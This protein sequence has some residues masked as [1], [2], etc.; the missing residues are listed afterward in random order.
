MKRVFCWML[1][2]FTIII[3]TPQAQ[4]F[5]GINPEHL[6]S[7]KFDFSTPVINSITLP[8]N[9]RLEYAEQGNPNGIPVI[10]LHG[11]SD[12]WH[13]F[14]MIM[15]YLPASLH[16]YSISQRGHGNS[17]KPLH[18]YKPEDFA[19]DIAD[20]MKVMDI[21]NPLLIG[22]SMGSTIVQCFASRYTFPTRGIILI[23]AFAD[24]ERP[25]IIEFK[26]IIDQLTDPVDSMFAAEFQKSTAYR[27]IPHSMMKL[28]IEE[29]G[30]LPAYVWKGVAAGWST[31][32]YTSQL[33]NYKKPALLIWGDKDNFISIKDQE[34]LQQPL[35]KSTLNVYRGTGHPTHWE[36]PE[37]MAKDVVDFAGSLK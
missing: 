26:K 19:K 28:F 14:D 10:M 31:S 34:K 8:S 20:L 17:S 22:H 12:S 33:K 1:I 23:G 37:R 32:V 25:D 3:S 13:S 4:D 5:E 15:P 36:E 9:V 30:E 6:P 18:G 7:G 35:P 11:F 21:K 27:P 29:S 16:V 24:Y 2:F